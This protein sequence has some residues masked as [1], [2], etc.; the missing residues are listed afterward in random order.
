[1]GYDVTNITSFYNLKNWITEMKENAHPQSLAILVGNKLDLKSERKVSCKKAFMFAR[2]HKLALLETSA[3]KDPNGVDAAFQ[4]MVD[5]IY[6]KKDLLNDEIIPRSAFQ[7]SVHS[8]SF[9][10]D[11]EV[12]KEE[13]ENKASGCG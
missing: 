1:M 5:E 7:H 2:Q 3:L 13:E 10:L 9:K 4:K 12:S 6:K 11:D 8:R